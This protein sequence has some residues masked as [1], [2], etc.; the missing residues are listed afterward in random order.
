MANPF[1]RNVT[2]EAKLGEVIRE[3]AEHNKR[4]AVHMAIVPIMASKRLR[5]GQRV[6]VCPNGI[7]S[8]DTIPVGIVDPFLIADV[9]PGQTFWLMLFQRTVTTLRHEW[10]HPSFPNGLERIEKD[11]IDKTQSEDWLRKYAAEHNSYDSPQEAY[12]NLLSQLEINEVRF[13]GSDLHSISELPD[14]ELLA[15][16]GS[17]VLG[18]PVTLDENTSIS[19]SC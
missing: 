4:D 15:Y 16:H 1:D 6:G 18:R 17:I 2:I 13:H 9:E 3:V 10:T 11:T 7:Y 14:R 12:S 5:P 8:D 19:C